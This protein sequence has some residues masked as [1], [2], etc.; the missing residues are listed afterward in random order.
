VTVD[1][2][3]ASGSVVSD[4]VKPDPRPRLVMLA[5]QRSALFDNGLHRLRVETRAGF[6]SLSYSPQCLDDIFGVVLDLGI[7]SYPS[8]GEKALADESKQIANNSPP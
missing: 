7:R 8:I 3:V 5:R 1:A 4:Q 2:A 6:H